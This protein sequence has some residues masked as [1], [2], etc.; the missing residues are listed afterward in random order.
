VDWRIL[1]GQL[2]GTLIGCGIGAYIT[3][4]WTESGRIDAVMGNLQKLDTQMRILTTTQEA[5]K[6]RISNEALDRQWRLDQRRDLYTNLIGVCQRL[7]EH[8]GDVADAMS[9]EED[10]TASQKLNE[11]LSE[12]YRLSAFAKI[13]G[14]QDCWDAL[15]QFSQEA[16][17]P[18]D[19]HWAEEGVVRYNALVGKLVVI[20]RR[21]FELES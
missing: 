3:G 17:Q 18:P 8:Y 21:E 10:K 16:Q 19:K 15:K 6:A 14:N 11:A 4:R 20:A 2:I 12:L 7:S 1:I 13:F 9:E 5:I